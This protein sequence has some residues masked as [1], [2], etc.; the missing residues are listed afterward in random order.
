MPG[1]A[2][3]YSYMPPQEENELIAAFELRQ[4]VECVRHWV[5]K[6]LIGIIDTLQ[7]FL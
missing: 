1:C 4:S 6:L 5:E 7:K 3:T 2:G